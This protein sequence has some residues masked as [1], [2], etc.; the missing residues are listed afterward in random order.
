MRETHRATMSMTMRVA[1]VATVSTMA[2]WTTVTADG[3]CGQQLDGWEYPGNDLRPV[4]KRF[5]NTST[6]CCDLCAA[7]PHCRTFTW[8]SGHNDTSFHHVCWLKTSNAPASRLEGHV[9]GVC[10]NPAP[11]PTP[12]FPPCDQGSGWCPPPPPLPPSPPPARTCKTCRKPP[13]SWDTL[14]V[15][16]HG[17]EQD[18]PGGGLSPSTIETVKHFPLV[19]LEKWQGDQVEPFMWEEDAWVVAARQIKKASPNT[20]VVVWLD[21]FRIYTAN[22]TLNPQIHSGCTTGHFRPAEYL[23]THPEMLLKNAT[24]QL[25]TEPWSG[26]NMYD[27]TQ[28]SVR[29]Y[30]T[31]MCLN[32]TDSGVIDGCGA[33]A[34]WQRDPTGGTT[35]RDTALAWDTGHRQMM[36]DTTLALGDGLLLGKDPWEIDYHVNGALH[37]SCDPT[38]ITIN[39]LR[40]LSAAAAASPRAGSAFSGPLVYECHTHCTTAPSCKDSVAAFL[41]GAGPY[42]YW[43]TGGWP[44]PDGHY[45]PD[46]MDHTLGAP[47]GDAV[48]DA[49]TTVWTRTF[50]GG[51]SKG[52][53]TVTFNVSA[54]SG[55][56]SW[57]NASWYA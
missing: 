7:T 26:C 18:A 28:A 30:W 52:G 27:F 31:D 1:I 39:T 3:T 43:G 8:V 40:N 42:H 13:F 51:A 35:S 33:D 15:F 21:S 2:P 49:T 56:I 17:C 22:K 57:L 32:L 10:A 41:I 4:T 53:T 14:P 47:D 55:S 5:T 38:N 19:T 25:A 12:V 23:E 54:G 24:G 36:R 29:Q 9:S 50:A 46:V 11:A 34:S 45:I 44:T 37:E 20:S 16:F 6:E 48:Y